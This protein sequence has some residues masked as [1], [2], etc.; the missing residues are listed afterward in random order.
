MALAGTARGGELAIRD[1][2]LRTLRLAWPVMLARAGLLV[3]AAV[4]TI[5]CGRAG[6]D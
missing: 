5:M 1:H 2:V 4:D 3:M 6:A